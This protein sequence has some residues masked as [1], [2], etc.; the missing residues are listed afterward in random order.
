MKTAITLVIDDTSFTFNSTEEATTFLYKFNNP[1]ED[2]YKYVKEYLEKHGSISRNHCLSRY[3]T[4]LS[5]IICKIRDNENWVITGNY[6]K[7]KIDYIYEL[8]DI[9]YVINTMVITPPTSEI[10]KFEIK[11]GKL[12]EIK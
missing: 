5:S 11:E 9:N 8:E 2:Q 6:G 7:N 3:I 12:K 1:I 4:R 10:F